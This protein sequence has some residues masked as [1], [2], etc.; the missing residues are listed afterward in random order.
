MQVIQVLHVVQ[1]VEKAD[2]NRVDGR[3]AVMESK[4]HKKEDNKN[5][6]Y[7]EI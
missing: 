1:P 7:E 3:R 5:N 4:G 6:L 2:Y